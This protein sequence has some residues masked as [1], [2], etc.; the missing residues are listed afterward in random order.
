[1]VRLPLIGGKIGFVCP[2][3]DPRRDVVTTITV[4]R[5]KGIVESAEKP[6][7]LCPESNRAGAG[8]D[9]RRNGQ[10]QSR[11]IR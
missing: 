8:T 6:T 2:R 11:P 1:M 9:E 7:I 3:F 4:P 10:S 5:R